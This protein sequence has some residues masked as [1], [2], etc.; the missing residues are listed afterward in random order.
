MNI[1]YLIQQEFK[2]IEG[3]LMPIFLEFKECSW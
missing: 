1:Y 2:V 3:D